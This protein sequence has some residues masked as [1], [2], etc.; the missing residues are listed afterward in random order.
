M[1]NQNNMDNQN[2]LQNQVQTQTFTK[3]AI[4]LGAGGFIG[5]HVVKQL[6]NRCFWVRGVDIKMH[7]YCANEYGTRFN[8]MIRIYFVKS[9]RVGE[10]DMA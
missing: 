7:E 8:F 5:S 10:I 1:N 4:V 6:K 3:R 9:N 2:N